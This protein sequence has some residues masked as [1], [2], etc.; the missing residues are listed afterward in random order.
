MKEKYIREGA[1][2]PVLVREIQ[3]AMTRFCPGNTRLPLNY[4]AWVFTVALVA[5][6]N[7]GHD[8]SLLVLTTQKSLFPAP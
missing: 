3:A 7:G 8:P 4:G 5:M 6:P 1:K 2:R